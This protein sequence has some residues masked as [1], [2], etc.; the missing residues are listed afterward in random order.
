MNVT[1]RN[2]CSGYFRLFSING[3]LQHH[4]RLSRAQAQSQDQMGR[5]AATYNNKFE[6]RKFIQNCHI[7]MET[8]RG[9]F[10][11][12]AGWIAGHETD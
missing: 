11:Y 12:S 9:M 2:C 3:H 5:Q 8:L 1:I 7:R 10:I 4:Q 6:T